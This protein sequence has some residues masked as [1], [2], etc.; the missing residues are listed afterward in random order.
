MA[1]SLIEVEP[2]KTEVPV[3]AVSTGLSEYKEAFST[4]PKGFNTEAE[5]KGTATQPAASY[6]NYLPVWNNETEK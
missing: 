2:P 1:P 5:M 6:P 3:K 4:G